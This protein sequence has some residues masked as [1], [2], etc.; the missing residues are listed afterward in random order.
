MTWVGRKAEKGREKARSRCNGVR[1]KILG[2]FV[3]VMHYGAED[4]QSPRLV[5]A[6]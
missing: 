1:E 5:A 4:E 2:M 3:V 6:T